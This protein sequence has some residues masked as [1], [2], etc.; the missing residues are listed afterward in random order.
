M[1]S[2]WRLVLEVSV[3]CAVIGGLFR[4][5][6]VHDRHMPQPAVSQKLQERSHSAP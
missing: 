5:L 6:S 4:G 2:V 1:R 3:L